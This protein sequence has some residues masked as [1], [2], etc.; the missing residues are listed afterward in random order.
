MRAL[1]HSALVTLVSLIQ[2]KLSNV[3]F[4]LRI[5]NEV[6]ILQAVNHPSIIRLE[7]VIDTKVGSRPCISS[8]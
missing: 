7:D 6:Q 2:I 4:V 8:G 1:Q 5:M 3:I